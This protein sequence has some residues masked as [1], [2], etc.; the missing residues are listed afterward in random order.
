MTPAFIFTSRKCFAI[1]HCLSL[2]GVSKM[3][4]EDSYC[5]LAPVSVMYRNYTGLLFQV[6][7]FG[8]P[9]WEYRECTGAVCL[10]WEAGAPQL[11]HIIPLE[12]R[13]L[14]SVTCRERSDLSVFVLDVLAHWQVL[15][16]NKWALQLVRDCLNP[17]EWGVPEAGRWSCFIC[18]VAEEEGGGETWVARS[19][20][21][22]ASKLK[23]NF[24]S[25][26]F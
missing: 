23:P 11:H 16:Y 19:L 1:S 7:V 4:E 25:A 5:L 9:G 22:S 10:E 26:M 18:C 24:L 6:G 3:P 17:S 21:R 13:L 12:K 2:E 20:E 8:Y 15:M 14:P